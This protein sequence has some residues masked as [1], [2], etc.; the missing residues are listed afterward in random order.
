MA[1]LIALVVFLFSFA[2][3]FFIIFKKLP[4]LAKTHISS[5]DVVH[6]AIADFKNKIKDALNPIDLDYEL[7]LQKI[8]SKVRVLTL[9]TENKTANWLEALRQRS[10]RNKESS[11]DYWE[12]LKKAKEGR[13]I[14]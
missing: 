8:L 14:K 7:Y 3:L 4:V 9:K 1:N 12:E 2:G 10:K 11:K 5:G 6:V 13:E